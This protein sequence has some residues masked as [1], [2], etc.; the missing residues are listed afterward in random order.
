MDDQ[1]DPMEF[2]YNHETYDH[3]PAV[4]LHLFEEVLTDESQHESKNNDD[5]IQCHEDFKNIDNIKLSDWLI[6]NVYCDNKKERI[7]V[8]QQLR[9]KQYE[10]VLFK[11]LLKITRP[12]YPSTIYPTIPTSIY[13][14]IIYTDGSFIPKNKGTMSSFSGF[15]CIIF[16]VQCA[17][18]NLLQL[19]CRYK[20][21]WGT[22]CTNPTNTKYYHG[23]DKVSNNVAELTAILSSCIALDYK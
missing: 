8:L 17:T 22:P 15:S 16:D 10:T 4:T 6:Q 1:V 23:A 9:N 21:M 5:D 2:T 20:D 14:F 12:Q 11:Q 13:K 7:R 19:A 18:D 3:I